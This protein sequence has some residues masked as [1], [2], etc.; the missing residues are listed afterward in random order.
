MEKLKNWCKKNRCVVL[1]GIIGL[2][3]SVTFVYLILRLLV[4]FPSIQIVHWNL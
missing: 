1:L 4:F 3:F 2:A